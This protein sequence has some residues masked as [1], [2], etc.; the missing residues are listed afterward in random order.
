MTAR[1][2]FDTRTIGRRMPAPTSVALPSLVYWRIQRGL[3]QADLADR[4]SVRRATIAR[5]EAGKPALVRTAAAIA[6][7]LG[8]Q[9]AEL[10]RQPPD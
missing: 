5:I 9:V 1:P 8:V 7:A 6:K 4:V 3:T 10:Q 2:P